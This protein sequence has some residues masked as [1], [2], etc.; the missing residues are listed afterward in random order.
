MAIGLELFLLVPEA[1]STLDTASGEGQQRPIGIPTSMLEFSTACPMADHF[2]YGKGRNASCAAS[3]PK[4]GSGTPHRAR[5]FTIFSIFFLNINNL[6]L[7]RYKHQAY[8][9]QFLFRF[10]RISRT[11]VLRAY[12]NGPA[13][14][15]TLC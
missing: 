7:C 5:I 15:L 4:V 2:F 8:Q 13:R 12:M 10:F 9:Y 6:N 11:T 1:G 3:L 14:M